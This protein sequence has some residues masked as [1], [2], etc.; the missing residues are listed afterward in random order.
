MKQASFDMLYAVADFLYA[1]STEG[2][3]TTILRETERGR[4]E[5]KGLCDNNRISY[6]DKKTNKRIFKKILK[7]FK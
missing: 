2:E 6:F 3:R 7:T 4:R 1:N 5:D